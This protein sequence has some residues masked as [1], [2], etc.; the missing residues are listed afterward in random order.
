MIEKIRQVAKQLAVDN[1]VVLTFCNWSFIDLAM[2]LIATLERVGRVQNLLM[3]ALDE[4]TLQFFERRKQQ[5]IQLLKQQQQNQQQQTAAVHI[6][7]CVLFKTVNAQ[8][9]SDATSFG[10]LSFKNLCHQKV[11]LVQ[12]L[13][14]VGLHVLWTDND[15][16]WLADPLA[17]IRQIEQAGPQPSHLV[18]DNG[19]L[20]D[21]SNFE[22]KWRRTSVV[23]T[24]AAAAGSTNDS[25][26]ALA[27]APV[28]L[29]V[30]CDDDGLCAGFFLIRSN[31]VAIQYLNKVFSFHFLD[32]HVVR[33]SRH[34]YSSFYE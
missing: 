33:F 30:Q 5:Q 15:I 32:F 34:T 8:Y 21:W 4:K 2:N 6:V 18:F 27:N 12:Q 16:V 14:E 11:Y 24:G 9:D 22:T 28:D 20:D 31:S 23:N 13:L 17:A 3:V 1:T 26:A 19:K 10:T 7:Q 25:S 29:F